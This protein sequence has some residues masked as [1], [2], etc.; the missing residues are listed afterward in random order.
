M[1]ILNR[2]RLWK[3]KLWLCEHLFNKHKFV[4]H[5]SSIGKFGIQY[6]RTCSRCNFA[7]IYIENV[8]A[9]GSG[10]YRMTRY[11]NKG[12]DKYLK[13]LLESKDNTVK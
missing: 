11:T 12:A 10:W 2:L 1:K 6:V 5:S 3:I 7:E 4:Y 8:P 9:Y 13:R